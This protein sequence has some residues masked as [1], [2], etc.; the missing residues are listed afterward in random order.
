MTGTAEESQRDVLSAT[1]LREDPG[2]L[3][4]AFAR[5][6]ERVREG[7]LP[8]AAMAIGDAD[9]MI[10]GETFSRDPKGIDPN[11]NFFLASVTKPIIATSFMQ[12]VEEGRVGLHQPIGDFD[13]R[14]KADDR[15]TVTPWH[16]LTHT[17][18]LTDFDPRDIGRKRPS[19]TDM[20]DWVIEQPLRFE[21]GTKW[22]YVSA[23]FYLLTLIIERVTGMGYVQHL[24]GRLQKPPAMHTTFAPRRAGRPIV[25]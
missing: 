3:D 20:T 12:L 8:A 16:I 25:A 23:T 2:R 21:P 4:E 14:M 18:G 7:A 13:P 1:R 11:S 17:S 24:K 6:A 22:E 9:G 15:A 10:R 5:L 19:A